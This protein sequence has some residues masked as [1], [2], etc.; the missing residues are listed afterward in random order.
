[1]TDGAGP[2]PDRVPGALHPRETP[3]LHGQGAAEA[4][5]LSAVNA[6]RL[7]HAWLLTGPRGTGKAT[8]A[9]RIARFLLA[10]PAG[11]GGG[12]FGAAPE[13]PATLDIAPDHPVARRVAALTE[14]RLFLLRRGLNTT[15]SALSAVIR[16]EEVRELGGFLHLTAADGGRRAVI[17]DAADDLHPSAANAL[18]KYLEEPPAG[19]C[20]LLV[21]HQPLSLLPTIRSRCRVL[22]LDA[23]A[24]ADAARAL[25]AQGI[26]AAEAER[27]AVLAEGSVGEAVR[28]AALDGLS[29]YAALV[30][31][32]AAA[33]GIDRAQAIAF[34]ARAQGRG[35]EAAE[36]AAMAFRLT[37]LFLSRLARAGAAGRT[38]PEAVPG[39]AAVL[40]RLAPDAGA[41]RRWAGLGEDLG[42]RQRR[43]LAV[44]LDPAGLLLDTLLRIDET[45]GRHVRR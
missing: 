32:F 14:P 24:P 40:A 29:A 35:G 17:V 43:G 27:L 30:A 4:A 12:L 20:F 44:N 10:T 8:L 25:A 33:P 26:A 9:W 31:L 42:R 37:G 16:V 18:L 41:A 2:E 34:A 5:F 39:E 21:S 1:M 3:A 6:G 19:V 45:A 13:A 22:R 7:H 15:G 23:L 36:E 28:L 38:G 11:D